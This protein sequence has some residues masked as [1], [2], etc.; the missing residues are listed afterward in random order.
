LARRSD[1]LV[2]LLA[3]PL[4]FA[5][6]LL[7]GAQY[8]SDSFEKQAQ[9]S[10]PECQPTIVERFIEG[11]TTVVYECP[12]EPTPEPQPAGPSRPR[13]SRPAPKTLPEAPPASDPADR[14]RLLA[15]VRDQSLDLEACRDHGKE[16]YRLTVILHLN[17][18]GAIARVDLNTGPGEIPGPLTT[19][20]RERLLTWRP[21][22]ELVQN[23]QQLVFG[24]TF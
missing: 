2:Q 16:V 17:D 3:T 7:F 6:G 14:Q 24:L 21:P 19:C 8:C 1:I 9:T 15:W 23:R 10:T 11:P 13:Q 22:A 4:A 5:V 18:Q 12:P 20:L